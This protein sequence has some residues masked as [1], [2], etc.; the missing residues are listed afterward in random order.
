MLVVAHKT[1]TSLPPGGG[2]LKTWKEQ[3]PNQG[4]KRLSTPSER[5]TPDSELLTFEHRWVPT[6]RFQLAL[7]PLH[8][9]LKSDLTGC[10]NLKDLTSV[11][12]SSPF[13]LRCRWPRCD[14]WFTED[15][16]S[17][18]SD[19]NR[20]QNNSAVC[21]CLSDFSKNTKSFVSWQVETFAGKY[22]LFIDMITLQGAL[23]WLLEMMS[24][25]PI[26]YRVSVRRQRWKKCHGIRK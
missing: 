19:K 2:Q 10:E 7:H 8:L 4:Q 21:M 15:H 24:W 17:G 20:I 22:L 12:S 1:F 3:D 6:F 26:A 18:L 5:W 16:Y 25:H 23:V 11:Y 14:S 13:T 9:L